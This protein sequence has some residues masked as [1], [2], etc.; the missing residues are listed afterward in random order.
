LLNEA[1]PLT[2]NA[3]GSLT[4][5]FAPKRPDKSPESNWL[6]TPAGEQYNLSFRFYGLAKD[7]EGQY[8][9]PPLVKAE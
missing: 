1:S 9:P 2:F 3:D 5:V 8:V 4:S 6:P 7:V